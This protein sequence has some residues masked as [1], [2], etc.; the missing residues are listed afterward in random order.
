MPPRSRFK[1]WFD[2]L[3]T[4]GKTPFVLSLSKDCDADP[5]DF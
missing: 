2:R 1:M 3:T 5:D 4:S